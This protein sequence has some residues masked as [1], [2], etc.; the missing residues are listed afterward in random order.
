MR[1]SRF[2][3][4]CFRAPTVLAVV[5]L[6]SVAWGQSAP[7]PD[8]MLEI[9]GVQ[10]RLGMD[11]NTVAQKLREKNFGIQE[12]QEL[13]SAQRK[14]WLLCESPDPNAKDCDLGQVSFRNGHVNVIVKHW[15]STKSA[16]EAVDTLYGATKDLEK[17]GYTHCQLAS[18]ETFEPGSEVKYVEMKCGEHLSLRVIHLHSTKTASLVAVEEMLLAK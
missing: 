2:A 5:V 16:V 6:A 7:Q 3:A 11:E 1:H 14:T 15:V 9:K 10:L 8:E 17:R 4:M 12:P 18:K 13:S